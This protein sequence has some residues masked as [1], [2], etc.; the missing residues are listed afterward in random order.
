MFTISADYSAQVSRRNFLRIGMSGLGG[1]GLPGLANGNAAEVKS[2]IKDKS[3]VLL[4]LGGGPPQHETFDPKMAAPDT[5]R[6]MFGEIKTT[7]PGV[8]FGS[9][10]PKL[11]ERMDRLAVIRSF[12]TPCHDHQENWVRRMLSGSDS[13]LQS[14]SIGALYAYFRGTNHP[15]TGVPTYVLLDSG[16]NKEFL[17]EHFLRGNS[18]GDLPQAFSPFN[19]AGVALLPENKGASSKAKREEIFSPI[20]DNMQLRLPVDQ[21][22][23][24]RA[25]V[26]QLDSFSRFLDGNSEF[27]SLDLYRQQA[28]R[29]LQGSVAKAFQLDHE[30]SKT[31]ARYDTSD[32]MM[33][34]PNFRNPSAGPWT[35]PL[36]PSL[37]GR[38]MLLAR[39]LCEQGA[40]F[41]LV[42]NCGWDFHANSLNPGMVDGMNG[43]GPQ[44]D[45]AVSAFLDDVHDRGLS[46]KILLVVTGEM[47]RTPK[48]NDKGG[49][50]HWQFLSP[51]LLAGGGLKMGQVIGKSDSQGG[52]PATTPIATSSLMGTILH[53]L[54]DVGQLRVQPGVRADL[55]RRVEECEPIQALL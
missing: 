2:H 33:S 19:P 46:D 31:L 47:G 51:L 35:F 14:P 32:I 53:T 5:V 3:V 39:R 24:R 48:I 52:R 8:T 55:V 9:H 20:F 40:G 43:N 12:H 36:R 23:D 7:L 28:H 26:G 10:F 45:R 44:L 16:Q 41:V 27:K 49:R 38:Q 42:E 50:D 17:Q 13:K 11:A 30:S 22:E 21:M 18:S 6:T 25:L 1:L 54:F 29:V 4:W 15:E 37:L 34:V